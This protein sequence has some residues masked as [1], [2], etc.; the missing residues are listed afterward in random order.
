MD[1]ITI[2]LTEILGV[3]GLCFS[4]YFAVNMLVR[5]RFRRLP[6]AFITLFFFSL[7]LIILFFQLYDHGFER[8]CQN[9]LPV[10]NGVI[11]C[12]APSIWAY[13]VHQVRAGSTWTYGRHFLLP[14]LMLIG[15]GLLFILV[16][17]SE[18]ELRSAF[19][20]IFMYLTLGNLAGL[21]LIQSGYYI[22]LSSRLIREHQNNIAQVFSY[23]EQVNLKW[24][25]VMN[26]G[27][28]VFLCLLALSHLL[29]GVASDIVFD[30]LMLTFVIFVGQQALKQPLVYDEKRHSSF[31]EAQP[32]INDSLTER[33][34]EWKEQLLE[35][36]EANRPFLDENLTVSML[37]EQLGTNTKYLSQTING[38]LE[39]SF[40]QFINR[41]RVE[42]VKRLLADQ[43]DQRLTMEA[44]GNMAGFKSKSAFNKAFKQIT[45][46]TPSEYKRQRVTA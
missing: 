41:Y 32:K 30:G 42:E 33:I 16:L 46:Q 35:H 13:I 43:A 22:V 3:I 45:G 20:Q 27:F 40:V 6:D 28:L 4:L 11:L 29:D 19:G 2:P 36:M 23:E 10:L 24:A 44:I 38:G 18:G 14:V 17:L 5:P 37:A 1:V 26:Y 39:E 31:P 15:S 8:L 21:F 12:L 34:T 7:G 9:T 25:K